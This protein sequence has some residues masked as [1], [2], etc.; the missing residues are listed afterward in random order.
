M[1][2]FLRGTLGQRCLA[3]PARPTHPARVALLVLRVREMASERKRPH[4]RGLRAEGVG[5]QRGQQT[6]D[7]GSDLG[8][9]TVGIG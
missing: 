1:R 7:D 8:T 6:V 5:L 2:P 9:R 4:V 3:V